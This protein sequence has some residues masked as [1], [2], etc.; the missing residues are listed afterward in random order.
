MPGTGRRDGPALR[1]GVEVEERLIVAALDGIFDLVIEAATGILGECDGDTIGRL[2]LRAL[3]VL[4][5]RGLGGMPT[6][7][8]LGEHLLEDAEAVV[9]HE[10]G[11]PWVSAQRLQMALEGVEVAG[12]VGDVLHGVITVL[13]DEDRHLRLLRPVDAFDQGH[14]EVAEVDTPDLLDLD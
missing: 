1:H 7:V 2:Q 9:A 13:V 6:G 8:A 4:R 3:D 10:R 11:A 5:E 14:P 12:V